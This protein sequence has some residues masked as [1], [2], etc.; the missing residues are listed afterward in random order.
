MALPAELLG[1]AAAA[2]GR[3]SL[4]QPRSGLKNVVRSRV[5]AEGSGQSLPR[6]CPMQARPA[7]LLPHRQ[8]V[9]G[10]HDTAVAPM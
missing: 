5:V 9:A 4:A 1:L 10:R 2:W 8:V 7:V 3:H 6:A